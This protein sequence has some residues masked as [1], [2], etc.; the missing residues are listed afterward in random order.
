V[1][2]LEAYH[3]KSIQHL[4]DVWH[5]LIAIFIRCNHH[6]KYRLKHLVDIKLIDILNWC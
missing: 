2:K 3:A 6:G 1:S 4:P 5:V